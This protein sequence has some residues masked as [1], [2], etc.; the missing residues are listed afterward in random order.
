[1]SKAKRPVLQLVPLCD[2]ADFKAVRFGEDI[3]SLR[4]LLQRAPALSTAPVDGKML[5]LPVDE[6][7]LEL[8]A[9]VPP[10]HALYLPPG[11]TVATTD[12][13][14]PAA[15]AG[16]TS[17]PAATSPAETPAVPPA[18]H[19]DAIDEKTATCLAYAREID[20]VASFLRAGLPVLVLCDKLVVKYLWKTMARKAGKEPKVLE[21]PEQDDGGLMPRSLRQ[22]QLAL[23]KTLIKDLKEGDILVIP[24]LD[25]LA[26][27]TDANLATEARELT[28]LVYDAG[29]QGSGANERLMLAF[30]DRSLTIPEVLAARFAVRV[31]INEVRSTVLYPNGDT[32]LLG[33][34]LVTTEEAARFKDF[35]PEGFY[36]N[37]AGM[38]PVRLR[39]AITYAVKE[40]AT[41]SEVSAKK[42]Y[43][44]I[45]AF[46]VQTTARF[47]VPDVV[48]DDIGGYADVKAEIDQALQLIAG[49]YR[50]P[51]EK[52][53]GEM[54][55]RGFIFYGPPGTGK[56]LFAKAIANELDATIQVVSGPEITD[57]YVG[58]SERKVREL[59]AAARRNAPAVLVFDE[60][61]SIATRRSGRD[62]G[63]SRA[64]NA[65]VAQ[66]LTEMDGFRPEVPMLVIGTT[67][68]LDIIDD[69]LLRPSRFQAIAIG[70]PDRTARLAIARVHAKHFKVDVAAGLLEVIAD[71][72]GG[73]NGDEIR[74]LFRDACVGQHCKNPPLP[75]DAHRFGML[76][77]RMRDAHQQRAASGKGPVAA[78][79]PNEAPAP[80]GPMVSLTPARTG[81]PSPDAAALTPGPAAL[82]SLEPHREGAPT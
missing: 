82:A 10:D 8:L 11:M 28:E 36:K 64:G 27:G 79:R 60:F 49:A 33:E 76:V 69:A 38:N 3:L 4:E 63:G 55:P 5:D 25:L 6:I 1:M 51:D 70:L 18:K 42:L 65:I 29:D 52:L 40:H 75:A 39:H 19:P 20:T 80:T 13:H 47:E 53:R 23:L 16:P 71:A 2:P 32:R 59:F 7:R 35:D 78:R 30:T 48:F 46:K 74:S 14:Q 26:G 68:R 56:T 17:R 62:D 57:M 41:G 58:E 81:A 67:N 61:D 77:G 50:L 34:A 43:E 12:G 31:S 72:T 73:F 44:A 45:K 37:V 54:I 66:I 21:V 15:P 9:E 22:R 24:H